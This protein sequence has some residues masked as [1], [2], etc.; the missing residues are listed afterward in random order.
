MAQLPFNAPYS[1]LLRTGLRLTA[2]N[3]D[4]AAE[5]IDWL[6]H[7]SV[8]VGIP[9]D[10]SE[11]DPSPE[12][13]NPASN[14][15]IGYAHEFGEPA[16]NLPARPFLIP[17]VVDARGAWTA[18]F[19]AAGR[20]AFAG[21]L[22]EARAALQRAGMRAVKSVQDVI[23]KQDFVELSRTTIE[24]RLRKIEAGHARGAARVKKYK[25]MT[26]LLEQAGWEA[27]NIKIL[28][29]TNQMFRAITYVIRRT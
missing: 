8:M 22:G 14:A 13:P 24:E 26:N 29:D 21:N 12:E 25:G 5:A 10:R 1:S 17:G 28:Q 18:S 2:D 19:E 11:R 15:V 9:D 4:K 6:S 20:A 3:Y 7:Q 16:H 23:L 27:A